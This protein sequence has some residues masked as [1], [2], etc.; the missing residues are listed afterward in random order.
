MPMLLKLMSSH[1]RFIFRTCLQNICIAIKQFY[2]L[3]FTSICLWCM[4]WEDNKQLIY[5]CSLWCHQPTHYQVLKIINYNS[6][7]SFLQCHNLR[8]HLAT[9]SKICKKVHMCKFLY[10]T[11]LNPRPSSILESLIILFQFKSNSFK[12]FEFQLHDLKRLL[13]FLVSI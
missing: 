8:M 9:S 6:S 1:F 10:C 11:S 4:T 13:N 2:L 7:F 3:P 5:I 12:N